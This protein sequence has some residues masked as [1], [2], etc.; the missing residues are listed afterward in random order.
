MQVEE[1]LWE[2]PAV[3]VLF[4]DKF[5]TKIPNKVKG[6]QVQTTSFDSKWLKLYL[7]ATAVF[8][9]SDNIYEKSKCAWPWPRSLECKYDI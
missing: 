6:Q 1:N 3:F 4:D 7:F 8:V 5:L 2:T 9:L